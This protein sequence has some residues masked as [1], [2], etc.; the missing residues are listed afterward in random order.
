MLIDS[1]AEISA[2]SEHYQQL[3]TNENPKI[4][5]IPVNELHIYNAIGTK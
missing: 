4:P 5:I 3:I 1:G 2:I